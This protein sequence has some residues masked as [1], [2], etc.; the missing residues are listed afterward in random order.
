MDGA[1]SESCS[2]VIVALAALGID[3]DT[4]ER[5]VKNGW[6]AVDAL[7][8]YGVS[9]GGFKHTPSGTRNG[10]A[11]EQ[12]YYALTAYFRV[13]EGKTSLYDMSD[14]EETP[15]EMSKGDVNGDG[16]VSADDLTMLSRH[17]AQI[18]MLNGAAVLKAADVTGDGQISADDLTVL[19]RYVAQIIDSFDE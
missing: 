18:E 8:S 2:Q 5:F 7:S 10:L 14:M 4:D 16:M 1:S 13:K 6:T 17:V 9:G 19:S 3:I 15:S 12:G 11:S